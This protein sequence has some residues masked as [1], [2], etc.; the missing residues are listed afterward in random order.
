M[1]DRRP[2]VDIPIEITTGDHAQHLDN[3][4]PWF[5]AQPPVSLLPPSSPWSSIG[6]HYERRSSS[7]ASVPVHEYGQPPAVMTPMPASQSAFYGTRTR[8]SLIDDDHVDDIVNGG[9]EF[10]E[11]N[12]LPRTSSVSLGPHF[13][14]LPWIDRS[15]FSSKMTGSRQSNRDPSIIDDDFGGLLRSIASISSPIGPLPPSP[16]RAYHSAQGRLPHFPF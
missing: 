10:L 6:H 13:H 16:N 9:S 12:Q 11:Y 14:P 5:P 8:A 2:A 1:C 4:L 7:G 15:S 3:R